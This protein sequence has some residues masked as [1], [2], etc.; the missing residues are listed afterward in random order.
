MHRIKSAMI[1]GLLLAVGAAAIAH[2]TSGA[3]HSNRPLM[4]VRHEQQPADPIA[5]GQE[6]RPAHAGQPQRME[7]QT[8]ERIIAN[9]PEESQKAAQATMKKYGAPDGATAS[10][11]EWQNNGPWKRTIVF[12]D[13]IDHHFPMEHKDVLQNVID[14][15]VPID[16]FDDLARFDGSIIAFRTG[17][18][19]AARCDDEAA[20]FLALNLAHE[21]I[22]GRR[23]VEDARDFYA[24]TIMEHKEGKPSEY[25]QGL[26]FSISGP[27]ADPDR[28]VHGPGVLGAPETPPEI[29]EDDGEDKAPPR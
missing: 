1:A 18:E 26:T 9:W 16:Q 27:T 21:I 23:S 20:N 11:L 6:R 24:R 25:T 15:K 5:P 7:M 14:Y 2:S 10:L 8:V 28:P 3:T 29:P 4:P 22:V 13:P 17:G 12:A 19:M